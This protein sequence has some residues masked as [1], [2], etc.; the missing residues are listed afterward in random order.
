MLWCE[1]ALKILAVFDALKKESFPDRLYIG[2]D[3]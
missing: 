2:V 1:F 3:G